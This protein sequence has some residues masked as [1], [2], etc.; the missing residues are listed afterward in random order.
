MLDLREEEDIAVEENTQKNL[1]LTFWVGDD[2]YG[3]EIRHVTEIIGILQ[4]TSVPQMPPYI[5]G[6]INLRG[7]IIPV[8]DMRLKF[9]M[10][11]IPYDERSCIVVVDMGKTSVGLIVD[12]VAAVLSINEGDVVPTPAMAKGKNRFL[13]GIGKAD[14]GVQLILDC[15]RLLNEGLEGENEAE[16]ILDVS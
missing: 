3:L 15:E 13:L 12:S 4:I 11:R 9:R 6:I 14:D 5:L 16:D 8:M 2:V 10:E 7:R 1:Y